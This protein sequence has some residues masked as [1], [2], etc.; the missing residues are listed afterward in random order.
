MQDKQSDCLAYYPV[1]EVKTGIN[2][3]I[4]IIIIIIYELI[5]RSLT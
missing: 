4:I 5:A 2:I 3:I 1:R